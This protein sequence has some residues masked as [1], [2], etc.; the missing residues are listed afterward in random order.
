METGNAR[1]LLDKIRAGE[2][3]Y[4]FVEIMACPGGCVNGGG[5]PIRTATE[6]MSVDFR[7]VRGQ[8]LY[9]AD[10]SLKLR[11]SHE[12]PEVKQLYE[13][14][15]GSPNSHKAHELLHTHYHPRSLYPVGKNDT[16]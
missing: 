13:E 11:K 15:L 4:H 16:N 5:Q 7:E 6:K 1:K 3:A 8:A 10:A 14:F 2:A 12:N 9:E